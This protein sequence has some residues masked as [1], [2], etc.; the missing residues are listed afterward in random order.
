MRFAICHSEDG[1][2]SDWQ[3]A[4]GACL[5]GTLGNT[6]QVLNISKRPMN[7]LFASRFTGN[8]IVHANFRWLI[9][10]P[11]GKIE[12]EHSHW[13]FKELIESDFPNP[14]SLKWINQAVFTMTFEWPISHMAD[15]DSQNDGFRAS[16][17]QK[18]DISH[19]IGIGQI[20]AF[21]TRH[22]NR[23]FTRPIFNKDPCMPQ[24]SPAIGIS[25]FWPWTILCI[26]IRDPS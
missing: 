5:V 26:S 4:Q 19:D 17:H 8:G 3:R 1:L 14:I 22:Q 7:L 2:G 9:E 11:Q 21:S 24:F 18:T 15:I 25:H 16:S 20:R 13:S 6:T 12:R 23:T 10:P